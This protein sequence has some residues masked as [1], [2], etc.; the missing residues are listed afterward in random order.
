MQTRVGGAS[1]FISRLILRMDLHV[2][3]SAEDRWSDL[4]KAARETGAVLGTNAVTLDELVERLTS[5][6]AGA[7]TAQRL[8]LVDRAM[9][10]SDASSRFPGLTHVVDAI[11]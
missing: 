1:Q 4:R 2:Y 11:T 3:R 7:T 9:R 5:D 6:L 8:L 10:E